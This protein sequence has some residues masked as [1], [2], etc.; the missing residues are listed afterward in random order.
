MIDLKRIREALSRSC[1]MLSGQEPMTKPSL[2]AALIESLACIKEIDAARGDGFDAQDDALDG[3][4]FRF[5]IRAASYPGGWPSAVMAGIEKEIRAE[6]RATPA[7]Y[8]RALMQTLG[9][10]AP[11]GRDYIGQPE[12]Y[13]RDLEIYRARFSSLDALYNALGEEALEIQNG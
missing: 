10:I 11:N 9:D 2:E 4:L 7:A 8:R 3:V 13:K 5:W 12:A 1:M 6:G